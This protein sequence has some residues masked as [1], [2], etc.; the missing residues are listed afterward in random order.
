MIYHSHDQT[1]PPIFV[2]QEFRIPILF[3]L[4]IVPQLSRHHLLGSIRPTFIQAPIPLNL[5]QPVKGSN[6]LLPLIL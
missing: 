1:L 4:E 5:M 3:H 6:I 2:Y